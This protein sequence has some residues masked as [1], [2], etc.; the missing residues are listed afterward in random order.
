MPTETFSK[1][2]ASKDL[3]VSFHT[4]VKDE[5]MYIPTGHLMVERSLASPMIY[6][7]RKSFYLA[8]A[9][10]SSEYALAVDMKAKD[11]SNTERMNE[12]L[13]RLKSAVADSSKKS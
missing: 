6:G 7:V 2:I 12:V 9:A 4:L 10:A 3:E 5:M 11:G 13:S 1:L 8:N